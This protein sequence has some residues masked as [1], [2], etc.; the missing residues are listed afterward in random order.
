MNAATTDVFEFYKNPDCPMC[1][2]DIRVQSVHEHVVDRMD[3]SNPRHPNW[4]LRIFLHGRR[5]KT[6]YWY[7]WFR[8]DGSSKYPSRDEE[9]TRVIANDPASVLVTHIIGI[10]DAPPDAP[11]RHLE[12]NIVRVGGFLKMR[13][14]EH[15]AEMECRLPIAHIIAMYVP[16]GG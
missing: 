16:L 1:R 3:L 14:A 2:G 12:P 6:Q 15:H 11:T 4:E 7:Y 13:N 9:P 8:L 5:Q 10:Y